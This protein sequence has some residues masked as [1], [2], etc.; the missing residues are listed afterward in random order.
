MNTSASSPWFA[1]TVAILGLVAGYALVM[2]Q[3]N[4]AAYA[5]SVRCPYHEGVRLPSA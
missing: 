3:Q 2:T 1:V 5:E 4:P